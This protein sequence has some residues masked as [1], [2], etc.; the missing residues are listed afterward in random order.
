MQ[1]IENLTLPKGWDESLTSEEFFEEVKKMLK[2]KF[3]ERDKLL[4]A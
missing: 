3:D 1:D 2:Q 4:I